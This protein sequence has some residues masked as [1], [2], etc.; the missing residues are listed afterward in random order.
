MFHFHFLSHTLHLSAFSCL[1]PLAFP[2]FFF[3]VLSFSHTYASTS[4]PFFLFSSFSLNPS[5]TSL[6]STHA[7]KPISASL[8]PLTEPTITNITSTLLPLSEP[9][10]NP[11]IL[12]ADQTHFSLPNQTH[13]SLPDQT[14]KPS[15]DTHI[16]ISKPKIQGRG[17][18][19]HLGQT[20]A[21]WYRQWVIRFC[22]GLGILWVLYCYHKFVTS[23]SLIG[24]KLLADS[25]PNRL[26]I[27]INISMIL[28]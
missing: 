26:V 24:A 10:T 19:F 25:T 7:A 21:P 11:G 2:H 8:L 15:L 23:S 22:F 1:S 3:L 14:Q 17:L 16:L 9:I 4:S 28:V 20:E 12:S 5:H 13:S 6:P 18:G 27:S